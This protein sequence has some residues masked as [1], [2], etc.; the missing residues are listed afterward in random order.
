[1]FLYWVSITEKVCPRNIEYRC[2]WY[3][4]VISSKGKQQKAKQF[5]YEETLYKDN[6]IAE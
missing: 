6:K 3:F 2:E 4:I 1:M 5:K